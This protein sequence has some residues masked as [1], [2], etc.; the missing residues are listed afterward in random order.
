MATLV[1]DVDMPEVGL[2]G[3][4]GEDERREA[5]IGLA[6]RSWIART[7][8]GYVITRHA[9][10]TAMLRD[11]RWFSAIGLIAQ[12]QGVDDAEWNRRSGQNI[13]GMEGDE[14]QRLR[15]LVGPAFTPKAAERLRPFMA[16]V[17]DELLD[18]LCA[19]GHGDFVTEVCEPYPIPIICEL[20]GAPRDD[21]ELFSRLATDIFRVFNG[22]LARDLHTIMAA[23]D[24]MGAYMSK[25]IAERRAEPRDDLLSDLIAAEEEGDRLTTEEM[26]SLANAVLLAG[27][28]TTRNQ[29]ACAVELFARC[30]DQLRLLRDEPS[31]AP[32]A[33]EE[34]MRHFGAIRGTA[35]YASESLVYRDIEFPASTLIFPSFTA[36][37]HDETQFEQPMRFD[38]TRRSNAPHMTFG[39]GIHYCLGAFL[40]RAELQEALK[41]VAK[42]MPDLRLD[43]DVEWKPVS[44]GIW[45][46]STLPIRFTPG[47]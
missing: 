35:R 2:G 29:L 26:Q 32:Q 45:G 14:H 7:P 1:A 18:P 25:L 44:N 15:R 34:V 9:D 40:A 5:L 37:N 17:I 27:T 10:V 30:P 36:A 3:D 39:S 19:R 6:E 31:L 38:I 4:E 11:K 24:E 20:L 22:N 46:P 8:L 21:W 43:G 16:E 33:A 28:D 12:M 42:R 23:Q 47:H 41:A 13:L